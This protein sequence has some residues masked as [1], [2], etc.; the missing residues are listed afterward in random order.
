[1]RRRDGRS[2]GSAVPG[3]PFGEIPVRGRVATTALVLA[4]C[5]GVLHDVAALS[6]PSVLAVLA[7]LLG[8]AV[9]DAELGRWAEGG[10]LVGQRPHKGLSAWPFAAVL[11]TGTPAAA[12]VAVPVYAYARRRGMRVVLWKWVGSCAVVSLAAV[13]AS[14]V[15]AGRGGPGELL[16]GSSGILLVGLAALAHVVV[17]AAGLWLCSATG[18]PSDEVWLRTQLRRREFYTAELAV[19]CQA[20]V[21]AGLWTLEPLLWLFVVPSYA[22]LQR[23]L[24]HAPLREQADHDGKTGLLTFAAWERRAEHELAVGQAVAVLLAD[25]DHFKRVNDS[26]GHLAGDAVLHAVAERLAASVR[27]VDVLG[28]FGGEEFCVLLPDAD[29]AEAVRVAERLRAAVAAAELPDGVRVTL[30]VGVHAVDRA[31]PETLSELLG[32]ADGALYRAKRTG[33]D[34]VVSTR[35]F[36]DRAVLPAPRRPAVRSEGSA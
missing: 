11:L 12:V 7:A 18:R 23:A 4:A 34:R 13:A 22:V 21:L 17:E 27:P 36:R 28:R 6:D 1:M 24:M 32:R 10:R 9:V 3:I 29:D 8:L 15:L 16:T 33:R 31:H 26:R 35:A 14:T 2:R 5:A 20:V 25:V 19:L 30:S